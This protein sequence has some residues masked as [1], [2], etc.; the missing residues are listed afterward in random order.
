MLKYQFRCAF[1][2]SQKC[3]M[4]EFTEPQRAA[5]CEKRDIGPFMKGPKLMTTILFIAYLQNPG[6][7]IIIIYFHISTKHTGME[8]MYYMRLGKC[9]F[10]I[11]IPGCLSNNN[12]NNNLFPYQYT[13]YCRPQKTVGSHGPLLLSDCSFFFHFHQFS[14]CFNIFFL[15]AYFASMILEV[16]IFSS[17]VPSKIFL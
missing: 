11:R 6:L 16:D 7:I 5:A 12:N 13:Q 14:L 4:G 9:W 3:H 2:F 8:Q 17:R 10:S 15:K 1:T